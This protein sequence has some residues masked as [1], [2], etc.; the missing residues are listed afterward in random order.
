[1]CDCTTCKKEMRKQKIEDQFNWIFMPLKHPSLGTTIFQVER[2]LHAFVISLSPYPFPLSL[3][4]FIRFLSLSL[5]LSI[6]SLLDILPLTLCMICGWSLHSPRMNPPKGEQ[7]ELSLQARDDGSKIEREVEWDE[8]E[9]FGGK[10]W[11]VRV[12]SSLFLSL[13]IS[14]KLSLSISIKRRQMKRLE[15]V[16]QVVMWYSFIPHSPFIQY[17][18]CFIYLFT[19]IE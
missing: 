9:W 12:G 11:F 13:S 16:L 1:M 8:W 10:N 15:R 5:S 7:E 14:I 2:K 19:P 17:M 3:S 6:S 4:F 18:L